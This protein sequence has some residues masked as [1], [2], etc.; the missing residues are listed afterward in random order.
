MRVGSSWSDQ[1]QDQPRG[2]QSRWQEGRYQVE[3]R[4]KVTTPKGEFVA[5]KLIMTMNVP[6]GPKP[7]ARTEVRTNTYYYAPDVEA[8]VSFH[9]A[10]TDGSL[11]STLIDFSLAK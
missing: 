10:W 11:T 5:F 3:A 4:E 2:F 6:I 9:E 7:L 1:F 8:I